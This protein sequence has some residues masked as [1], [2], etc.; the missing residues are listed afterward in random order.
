M[1]KKE[2]KKECT[3][4]SYRKFSFRDGF[5]RRTGLKMSSKRAKLQITPE[6]VYITYGKN[7]LVYSLPKNHIG[8]FL[9]SL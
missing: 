8:Q 7:K 9:K 5:L 1:Q 3:I 6:Q 4:H 2:E